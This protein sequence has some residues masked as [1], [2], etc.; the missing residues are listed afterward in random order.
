MKGEWQCKSEFWTTKLKGYEKEFN[1][2]N[3]TAVKTDSDMDMQYIYDELKKKY[4]VDKVEG[5]RNV[6]E[7][8]K[9]KKDVRWFIR[10]KKQNKNGNQITA[11][12]SNTMVRPKFPS[13]FVIGIESSDYIICHSD[14]KKEIINLFDKI[15]D[16]FERN[17]AE[18]DAIL[19]ELKKERKIHEIAQTSIR[20]IIPAIMSKTNY[21]WNLVEEGA[22]SVLQI[23]MK[24]GKMMEISLGHKSFNDKI[25]DILKVIEQI[26]NLLDTIPYPVDIKNYSRKIGW[27]KG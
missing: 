21:E 8:N 13:T 15:Y 26:E 23:K 5:R 7:N 24:R 17:M 22:R 2:K 11:Y 20:T 6:Y 25:P 9:K 1:L 3:T 19:M 12:I 27:R 16:D 14:H 4:G 10:V 18:L